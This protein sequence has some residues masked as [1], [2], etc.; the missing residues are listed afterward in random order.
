MNIGYLRIKIVGILLLLKA[1]INDNNVKLLYDF[2]NNNFIKFKNIDYKCSVIY[3]FEIKYILLNCYYK[4]KYIDELKFFNSCFDIKLNHLNEIDNLFL[5]V[6]N[7][8]T[9]KNKF[10][11]YSKL[12]LNEDLIDK[13]YLNEDLID[14]LNLYYDD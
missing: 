14:K 10:I 7:K 8:L 4:N 2:I 11:F 3:D 5:N 1:N 12:Y 6:L 9:D 13:L